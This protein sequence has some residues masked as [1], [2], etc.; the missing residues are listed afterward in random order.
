[1]VIKWADAV[2]TQGWHK[3]GQYNAAPSVSAGFVVSIDVDQ[4]S[5]AA[6]Y[7]YEEQGSKKR[8]D[9][10]GEVT[11]IPRGMVLE[12]HATGWEEQIPGNYVKTS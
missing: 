9:D 7:N 8:L 12:I 10:L 2:T 1:M 11:T 4:V 6:N 5:V 3:P